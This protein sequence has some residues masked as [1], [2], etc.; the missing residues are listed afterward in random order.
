MLMSGSTKGIQPVKTPAEALT[1]Y[2]GQ[3][4]GKS[5]LLKKPNPLRFIG[6]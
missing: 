4:S 2:L 1:E 3:G 5:R 6:F